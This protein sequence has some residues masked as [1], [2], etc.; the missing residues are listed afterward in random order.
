MDNKK[1]KRG[2]RWTI[3][4]VLALVIAAV[5]GVQLFGNVLRATGPA[6]EQTTEATLD[7]Q[8]APEEQPEPEQVDVEIAAT[9]SESAPAAPEPQPASEPAP[10][11]PAPAMPAAVNDARQTGGVICAMTPK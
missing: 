7:E 9:T 6:E 8:A 3:A 2:V 5:A 11:E 10:S 1:A 4:L